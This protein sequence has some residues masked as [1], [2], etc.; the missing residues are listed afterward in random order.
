M[1]HI[2]QRTSL[3]CKTILSFNDINL[4]EL[5]SGFWKVRK[6]TNQ[7]FDFSDGFFLITNAFFGCHFQNFSFLS[8]SMWTSGLYN[9]GN[10]HCIISFYSMAKSRRSR[11]HNWRKPIKIKSMNLWIADKRWPILAHVC[12]KSTLLYNICEIKR[13]F[14]VDFYCINLVLV[15]ILSVRNFYSL[16]F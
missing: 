2:V 7:A 3:L 13:H 6:C 1:H 8:S 12:E 11:F 9:T 5:Y 16:F 10:P 14:S 15:I 4:L